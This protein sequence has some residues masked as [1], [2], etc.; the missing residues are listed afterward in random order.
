MSYKRDFTRYP[1]FTNSL[2]FREL[3]DEEVEH[4]VEADF[5]QTGD[6]K[7]VRGLTTYDEGLKKKWCDFK[8]LK[9]ARGVC[10]VEYSFR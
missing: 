9:L 8:V 5:N 4:F 7:R 2:I 3:T 6:R 1:D 10:T